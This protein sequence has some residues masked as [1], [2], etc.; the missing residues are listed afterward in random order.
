MGYHMA[1]GTGT[2]KSMPVSVVST[3]PSGLCAVVETAAP[4]NSWKE[5]RTEGESQEQEHKK[6]EGGSSEVG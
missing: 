2:K 3:W 6:E 5:K 4:E 1:P